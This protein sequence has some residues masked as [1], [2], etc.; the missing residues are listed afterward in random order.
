MSGTNVKH[1]GKVPRDVCEAEFERFCESNFLIVDQ[2]DMD[3]EDK[4]AYVDARRK[5][6]FAME[7]G[8][9]VIDEHGLPVYTP[10]KDDGGTITVHRPRG[11]TFTQA[12]MKKEARKA[13]RLN[14]M[15]AEVTKS[16]ESRFT[17]MDYVDLRVLHAL[18]GLFLG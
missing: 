18:L 9:L 10:V 14:A 11:V 5:I 1:P 3:D 6:M 4:N 17:R 8:D 2:S 15:L 16:P 13:A 7:R 12:D